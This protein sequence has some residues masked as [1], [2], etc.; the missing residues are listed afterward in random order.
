MK[1]NLLTSCANFAEPAHACKNYSLAIA[2][3]DLKYDALI[4]CLSGGDIGACIFMVMLV[5]LRATR[6]AIWHCRGSL[7]DIYA[8]IRTVARG[9]P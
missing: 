6:S 4:C 9:A 7:R 2:M 8:N 3:A 1:Q 5:Y